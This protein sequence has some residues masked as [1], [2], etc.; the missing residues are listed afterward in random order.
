MFTYHPD[1]EFEDLQVRE[2]GHLRGVGGIE[3]E[4]VMKMMWIMMMMV[5]MVMM[6][7]MLMVMVG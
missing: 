6:M 5:M 3:I 7:L 4:S 1:L 2:I